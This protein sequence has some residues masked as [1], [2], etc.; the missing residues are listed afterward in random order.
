MTIIFILGSP[1]SRQLYFGWGR[2]GS[3][4]NECYLGILNTSYWYGIVIAHNGTRLSG[5]NATA[6]NLAACFDIRLMSS[7]S[8]NQF[9]ILGSNKST[10]TAWQNG[11]TGN[12]MDRNMGG[13]FTI[14]GRGSNRSFQGKVAA[15]VNTTLRVNQPMPTDAELEMMIVDP[16]KW[17]QDYKEGET[18]RVAYGQSEG[19]FQIVNYAT[20]SAYATQVWLMGDGSNDSYSNMIRNQV[21]KNDQNYTKLNLLSMVSNDIETINIPGLS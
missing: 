14:G 2:D 12:R 5:N 11:S 7:F 17:L 19:T 20:Y 1:A 3:G 21:Y 8:A 9:T 16:V 18:F 13:A 10:Q 6:A 4:V 15:M